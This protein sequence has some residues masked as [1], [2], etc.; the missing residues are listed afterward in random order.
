MFNCFLKSK[1]G[2]YGKSENKENR[3]FDETMYLDRNP[4]CSF[5]KSDL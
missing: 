1:L 2:N 3:Q 4:L 5:K